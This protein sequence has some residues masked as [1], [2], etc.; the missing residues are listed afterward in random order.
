MVCLLLLCVCA[1][2]TTEQTSCLHECEYLFHFV[3]GVLSLSR[4]GFVTWYT[5]MVWK[6]YEK[7]K[8]QQLANAG[9]RSL[10][11]DASLP[12]TELTD[13]ALEY[14]RQDLLRARI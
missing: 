2:E 10:R 7:H 12:L 6:Y 9:A 14:V 3:L 1:S 4:A 11:I 8:P 5:H 13:A